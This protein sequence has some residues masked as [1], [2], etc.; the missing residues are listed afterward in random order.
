MAFVSYSSGPCVDLLQPENILLANG[1]MDAVVKVTDFGLAKLVGPHS[2]MKTMC[3]TPD[4]LAP[5]V[6]KTGMMKSAGGVRAF[7]I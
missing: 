2:F 3:G 1:T 6:L 7:Y 5:E 4:Y